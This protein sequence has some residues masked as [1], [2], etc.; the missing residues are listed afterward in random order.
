MSD[1]KLPLQQ[2]YQGVIERLINEGYDVAKCLREIATQEGYSPVGLEA[3]EWLS[4]SEYKE[5]VL[6]LSNRIY[7]RHAEIGKRRQQAERQEKERRIEQYKGWLARNQILVDKFLEIADR[8]VSQLDDYGDEKWDAL[9]KEIQTCLLKLARAEDDDG[10]T[11]RCLRGA[12][13]SG[14]EWTVPE[15][16]FR[17]EKHPI[18]LEKYRWLRARLESE[19]RAFHE[20][21]SLNT[22]KPQFEEMSGTEFETFLASL[23]KQHG[24]ENIRGTAATGD[25]G[26]DLLA[27]KA[28]RTIV[29]QAKRY[30]GAVGNKAVQEVAAAV[31]FYH[32]DEGWVVTS[33][34]FTSSAKAL[35]QA[36]GVRLI[37]GYNLRHGFLD[38]L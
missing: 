38:H 34:T 31:R 10:A 11:E 35:A 4:R 19:F 6:Y 36:N 25:Q 3:G 14:R 27:T 28:N 12:M 22:A 17:P 9:P 33:G 37:D 13:K 16:Y 29:I 7:A 5:L 30:R 18:W 20:Q 8:K 21:R 32:A 23:L 15:K 26:G 1:D 24:F 2:R